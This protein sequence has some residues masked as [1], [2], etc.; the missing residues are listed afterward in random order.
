[1]TSFD[2]D[3]DGVYDAYNLDLS[4]NGVTDTLAVDWDHDGRAERYGF[5]F[6]EDGDIDLYADDANENGIFDMNEDGGVLITPGGGLHIQQDGILPPGATPGGAGLIIYP[7]PTRGVAV[8][9]QPEF[10][11]VY[12]PAGVA[13]NYTSYDIDSDHDGHSD[14]RDTFPADPNRW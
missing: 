9:G 12:P 5:D 8:A 2:L 11:G 7:D 3:H 4:G 13:S 6:D 10:G 14:A 1:M